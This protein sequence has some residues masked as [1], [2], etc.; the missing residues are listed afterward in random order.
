MV[1]TKAAGLALLSF[2]IAARRSNAVTSCDDLIE[3]VVSSSTVTLE[4]DFSCAEP[5]TIGAGTDVTVEGSHTITIENV[6]S[7]ALSSL[8]VNEGT[9][10]L[11]GLTINSV[12]GGGKRAIH[13]EGALEV[14]GCT[15]SSLSG[16]GEPTLSTGGVVS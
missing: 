1:F 9:L 7:G 8:F 16:T 5:I 3:A 6:F 14:D 2:G 15:F 10:V 13:N 4:G 12:A 11:S